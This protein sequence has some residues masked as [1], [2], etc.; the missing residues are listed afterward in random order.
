MDNLIGP[1]PEKAEIY[2]KR[3]P[4]NY[5]DQLSCPVIFFQGLDD[6]VVPP[7]QAEKLYNILKEKNIPTCYVTYEGEGHGFRQADNIKHS[8]QSE[9]YFYSRIFKLK[10]PE[11]T[12]PIQI[13]NLRD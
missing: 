9:L 3:S 5:P 1:Y 4:I 6:K 7:N 8:L 2:K 12:A 13:D 11:A 10:Y